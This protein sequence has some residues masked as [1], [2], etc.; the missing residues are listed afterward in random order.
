MGRGPAESTPKKIFG[1]WPC[2]KEPRKKS[3]EGAPP[4]SGLA[5]CRSD[6]RV[7]QNPKNRDSEIDGLVRSDGLRWFWGAY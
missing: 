7:T 5:R 2:F 4:G 1:L 3:D 6:R